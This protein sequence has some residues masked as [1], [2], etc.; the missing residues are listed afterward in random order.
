MLLQRDVCEK[1]RNT[2]SSVHGRLCNGRMAAEVHEGRMV[3]FGG[4][5]RGLPQRITAGLMG[6]LAGDAEARWRSLRVVQ[7]RH[8]LLDER[9]P[10]RLG[11]PM[12]EYWKSSHRVLASRGPVDLSNPL[13]ENAA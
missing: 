3:G 5:A 13:A 1:L 8:G 2:A 4:G 9:P 6:R 7:R 12:L 11:V 10:V